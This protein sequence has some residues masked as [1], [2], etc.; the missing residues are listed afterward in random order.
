M[1]STLSRKS[2]RLSMTLVRK[3]LIV[4]GGVGG[5]SLAICLARQQHAVQVIDLDPEWRAV[6]AGLSLNNASL[7]AIDRVGVLGEIRKHGDVHAGLKLHDIAGRP[8]L[9]P[10]PAGGGGLAGESG[11]ILRPVLHKILAD[12]TRAS[13]IAVELGVTVATLTQDAEGVDI[14]LSNGRHGRYDLVIGAD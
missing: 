10:A 7:R 2:R 12:A 14:T 13:G 1:I 6:G 11:G 5:M 4:G 9:V 3:I 8:V